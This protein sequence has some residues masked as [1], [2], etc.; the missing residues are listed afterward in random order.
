M[1]HASKA[2]LVSIRCEQSTQGNSLDVWLGRFAMVG[3]TV[4]ISV[5]IAIGK[6]LLEV[7]H[8]LSAILCL[9]HSTIWD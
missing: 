3:F 7:R 1:K 8:P 2:A 9:I 5:E 4:A 6:G